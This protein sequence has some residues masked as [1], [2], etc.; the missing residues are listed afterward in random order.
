MSTTLNLGKLIEVVDDLVT[1]DSQNLC[2]TSEFTY[3]LH[4]YPRELF[5]QLEYSLFLTDLNSR[6]YQYYTWEALKFMADLKKSPIDPRSKI[7]TKYPQFL[8]RLILET[9]WPLNTSEDLNFILYMYDCH[10]NNLL[11]NKPTSQLVERYRS[12]G[13]ITTSNYFKEFYTFFPNSFN[14][15]WIQVGRKLFPEL[16]VEQIIQ[17]FQSIDP[18]LNKIVLEKDLAKAFTDAT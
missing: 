1:Q 13:L 11:K 3:F 14:S 18:H 15:Q 9:N 7:F 5:K 8:E 10:R 4:N 12:L 17:E 6:C 16:T 2:L